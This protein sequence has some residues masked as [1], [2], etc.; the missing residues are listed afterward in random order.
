MVAAEA[1]LAVV[2]VVVVK[3]A[4]VVGF[5]A[6]RVEV[7]AALTLSSPPL[8][9]LPISLFLFLSVLPKVFFSW[10]LFLSF[11]TKANLHSKPTRQANLHEK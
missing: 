6:G 8:S 2:D 9:P 10:F 1:K 5:R 7:K 4:G 3:S 11:P